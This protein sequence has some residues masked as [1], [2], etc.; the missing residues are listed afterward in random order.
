MLGS[1]LDVDS[2]EKSL[3]TVREAAGT[4][5][6]V[7]E[8]EKVRTAYEKLVEEVRYVL[9]DKLQATEVQREK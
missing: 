7:Q 9:K 8:Y 6:H 3:K 4:S 5:W 1:R 2:A